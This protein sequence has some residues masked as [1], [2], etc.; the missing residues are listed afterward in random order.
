M[1]GEGNESADGGSNEER[2]LRAV[3]V[4]KKGDGPEIDSMNEWVGVR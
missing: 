3:A 4:E 2:G 1:G